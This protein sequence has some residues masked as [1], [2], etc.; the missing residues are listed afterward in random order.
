[1]PVD[2]RPFVCIVAGQRSGSTALRSALVARKDFYN[3]RELFQHGADDN[4]GSFRQ[5]ADSRALPLSAMTSFTRVDEII[6]DYL[7]HLQAQAKGKIPVI[8]VKQNGWNA[9][10]PFWSH[11]LD[12]P[13]LMRRLRQRGAVFLFLAR[14]DLTAQIISE[15][16]AEATNRWHNL[17][18]GDVTAPIPVDKAEVLR[19]ARV[20]LDNEKLLLGHL[21]LSDRVLPVW[22]EDLYVD[23]VVHPHVTGWLDAR[24]GTK[25]GGKLEPKI[26]RNE[27]AKSD[28]VAGYQDLV[29][30]VEA[31][32]AEQGRV[33]FPGLPW[34]GV[35]GG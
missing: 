1:M 21:G 4:P 26:D 18:A 8:D 25:L 14:R 20:I 16:I 13:L 28:V 19:K 22:Y 33:A 15:K 32:I 31:L 24:L 29:R 23:G 6:G 30:A 2:P 34:R 27:G 12:E 11:A 7:D 17:K 5:F 10:R 9:L 3:C 35:G